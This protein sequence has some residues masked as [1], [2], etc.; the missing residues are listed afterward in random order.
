LDAKSIRQ[1]SLSFL[2]AVLIH[3]LVLYAFKK[4]PKLSA[5]SH[6]SATKTVEARVV[7]P[8]A[9]I[10]HLQERDILINP[11]KVP[12]SK[13]EIIEVSPKTNSVPTSE[14]IAPFVQTI[15][16]YPDALL[17]HENEYLPGNELD[18]T[19]ISVEDLGVSLSKIFPILSGL[20]ILELW[21]DTTGQ[22]TRIDLIQG[23]TLSLESD[24]MKPLLDMTFAPAI[25]NGVPVSSR[26][27]IEIN[28]DII[29][30]L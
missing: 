18:V 3:S 22:V 14:A 21:I 5:V 26:K 10:G 20:I 13:Q 4:S 29:P 30:A 28:T 17:S 6:S 12:I 9:G 1:L 8:S 25:K 15:L 7:T 24:A 2:L 16:K 23:Q 19:A 11:V 27:L